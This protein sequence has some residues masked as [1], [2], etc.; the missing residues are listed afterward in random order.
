MGGS[1]SLQSDSMEAAAAADSSI[2]RDKDFGKFQ[3]GCEHY[4]RRCK[5]RAP[6][7]NLIFSCRHCHN[8]SAN[9]LPDP[10]ERHDLVRQNVKQVVCSICQTE[11]EVAKVCSNCGVN[12][13]EY[14]C[15]ICKFFDDDISKEQFHCDDCGICRV[16]GRDKFFHCQNCGA[17]YGMG[18]RDK[19]SCIENSTKNSCP[20]CY[21]YLFDSV[22]AAHV[23]KCGHTMHMDCF[24]QMINE[25][26]YRCPICAK[27]MVD[28]SPSWHLLDFEVSILCNDCNKGSKAMFHILGHKCSD[29]GSYNTR[30][31]STPQDPVSETE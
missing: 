4:K 26:Q 31:I 28:M 6:C 22:K 24:E 23:M 27:S 21:E 9:S 20:V 5:I 18:L 13:G 8:D 17:C 2:P 19:H 11:Q 30:R 1:A 29:C 3:F 7:C 25:N 12:M 14:F 15:D 16:G 10:K